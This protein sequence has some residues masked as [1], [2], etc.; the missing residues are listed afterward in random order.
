M[1]E[2]D[3]GGSTSK[4]K[5][6][7]ENQGIALKLKKVLKLISSN[8]SD[9]EMD[10]KELVLMSSMVNKFIKKKNDN[11]R[12]H[13]KD[14]ASTKKKDSSLVTC[15]NCNN[16]GHYA[17]EFP[18]P[19]KKEQDPAAKEEKKVFFTWTWGESDS[20]VDEKNDPDCLMARSDLEDV[21]RPLASVKTIFVSW[22]GKQTVDP[23]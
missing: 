19:R 17:K 10:D 9:E 14:R 22:K 16:K 21:D 12:Y 4:N 18:Q 6:K 15:Y 3:I 23:G 11:S 2:R 5:D 7:S 20:D 1:E 8:A 13:T